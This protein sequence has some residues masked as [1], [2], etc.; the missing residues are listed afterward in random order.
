MGSLVLALS[1]WGHCAGDKATSVPNLHLTYSP[2]TPQRDQRQPCCLSCPCEM[3]LAP[4]Q[5]DVLS[6]GNWAA[7][8]NDG[9]MG[10]FPSNLSV[11]GSN[12]LPT[13]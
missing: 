11:S 2:C 9:K 8:E 13:G 5:L 3:L 12:F 6:P 10:F 7:I 4:G 1:P